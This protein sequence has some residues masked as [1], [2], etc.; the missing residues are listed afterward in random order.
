MGAEP[1]RPRKLGE[2][3]DFVDWSGQVMAALRARAGRAAEQVRDKDDARE[4]PVV[5]DTSPHRADTS[6]WSRLRGRL[7]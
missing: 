4:Q 7:P 2:R 5:P 3:P 1:G 6:L